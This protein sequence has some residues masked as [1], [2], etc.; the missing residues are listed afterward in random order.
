MGVA[1]TLSPDKFG[2]EAM[3]I[4]KELYRD[5]CGMV[6]SAEAVLIGT[7][8]VIGAS[9]GLSAVAT[10]V[11]EELT[12]VACAFRSLDQ[13]FEFQGQK[14]CGAETAGSSYKQP[15]ARKSIEKLKSHCDEGHRHHEAESKAKEAPS[16]KKPAKKKKNKRTSV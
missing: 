4:L 3:R 1:V 15:D 11:N 9:V 8:G 5:E 2:S 16:K 12:D 6:L 7:V 10:S 14:R 13:S